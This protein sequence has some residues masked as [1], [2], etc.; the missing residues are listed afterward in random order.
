MALE[1]CEL[2]QLGSTTVSCA[3]GL[4]EAGTTCVD[5]AEFV[6]RWIRDKIVNDHGHGL[7]APSRVDF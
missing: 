2:K 6:L 7:Q 1:A 4:T 5:L 3:E